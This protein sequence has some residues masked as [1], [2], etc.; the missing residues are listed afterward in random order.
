MSIDSAILMLIV[1][2]YL[3]LSEIRNA[4]KS[5]WV[6]NSR[7]ASLMILFSFRI[8]P[9][10]NPGRNDEEKLLLSF[11]SYIRNYLKQRD[12]ILRNLSCKFESCF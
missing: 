4:G 6:V 7:Y 3:V 12:N 10:I 5:L 9:E 8:N 11:W 1:F 2:P